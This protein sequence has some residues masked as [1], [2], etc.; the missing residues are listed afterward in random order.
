MSKTKNK[1]YLGDMQGS[2]LKMLAHLEGLDFIEKIDAGKKQQLNNK[3]KNGDVDGFNEIVD[4]LGLFKNAK[5]DIVRNTELCFYGGIFSDSEKNLDAC[6]LYLMQKM[7]DQGIN[8]EVLVSDYDVEFLKQIKN[9]T[10]GIETLAKKSILSN[11]QGESVGKFESWYD[12]LNIDTKKTIKDQISNFKEHLK[13]I[14]V[15]YDDNDKAHL[16]TCKELKTDDLTFLINAAK[17][18]A[19][20]QADAK[21]TLQQFVDIINKNFSEQLDGIITKGLF[22]ISSEKIF[23]EQSKV[24]NSENLQ[25]V[26]KDNF[27]VTKSVSYHFGIDKNNNN[28]HKHLTVFVAKGENFNNAS[29]YISANKLK[30][31]QYKVELVNS[32]NLFNEDSNEDNLESIQEGQLQQKD[33]DKGYYE[34][35]RT[36]INK[37]TGGEFPKILKEHFVRI[38]CQYDN[39]CSHDKVELKR[40]RAVKLDAIY[41]IAEK[42]NANELINIEDL[43]KLQPNTGAMGKIGCN[44]AS[45]NAIYPYAKVYQIKTA[46][47]LLAKD[48]ENGFN[49]DEIDQYD[50]YQKDVLKVVK[51]L[52]QK[53]IEKNFDYMC[54]TLTPENN[55]IINAKTNQRNLINIAK[56]V[57]GMFVDILRD[58]CMDC[59]YEASLKKPIEK[60]NNLLHSNKILAD[61]L[62]YHQKNI[63]NKIDEK[64]SNSNGAVAKRLK[65][66]K[67][68]KDDLNKANDHEQQNPFNG[69]IENLHDRYNA[70]THRY[71]FGCG[72]S[73]KKTKGYKNLQ[74]VLNEF[75]QSRM[76]KSELNSYIDG[77]M[78]RLEPNYKFLANIKDVIDNVNKGKSIESDVKNKLTSQVRKECRALIENYKL[79]VSKNN[80][81]PCESGILK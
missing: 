77:E 46:F 33:K 5:N 21:L 55:I 31:E 16:S 10:S 8:Y 49:F 48:N 43:A 67:L 2:T 79:M 52:Y 80:S 40:E 73:N 71:D 38:Q 62:R 54:K 36:K 70:N 57:K 23:S 3:Y 15:V 25:N 51:N 6:T 27:N 22:A 20:I 45:Y 47:D 58:V 1:I 30:A 12:G 74:L 75:N 4:K 32:Q 76:S 56:K 78:Q 65:G 66:L 69:T 14:S 39:A 26:L 41:A 17:H 59:E 24:N 7:K 42:I 68:M 34:T 64:E 28:C 53:C 35:L 63:E 9:I 61:K 29:D 44:A 50:D 13:F 72:E 18:T 11:R 37:F 81:F 60:Y 19:N